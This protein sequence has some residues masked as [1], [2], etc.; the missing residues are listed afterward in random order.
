MSQY[1]KKLSGGGTADSN[2]K[3][4]QSIKVFKTASGNYDANKLAANFERN[5]DEYVNYLGFKKTSKD[6]KNFITE[7]ARIQKGIKDGEFER[8]EGKIYSGSII[9]DENKYQS[10]ALGLLDKIIDASPEYNPETKVADT[11]IKP[12]DKNG[13]KNFFFDVQFGGQQNPELKSW[14][15]LDALPEDG[16]RPTTNRANTFANVLDKYS[17]YLNT[18]NNIDWANSTYKTKEEYQTRLKN[19]AQELRQSGLSSNAKLLLNSIGISDQRQ[20]ELF[21]QHKPETKKEEK[22]ADSSNDYATQKEVLKKNVEADVANGLLTQEEAEEIVDNFNISYK[23]KKYNIGQDSSNDSDVDAYQDYANRHWAGN[24]E[25]SSVQLY[26]MGFDMK[27]DKGGSQA[28]AYIAHIGDN[29]IYNWYKKIIT[30]IATGKYNV[31]NNNKQLTQNGPTYKQLLYA[32]LEYLLSKSSS[33]LRPADDHKNSFYIKPSLN[34]REGSILKWERGTGK[35]FKV[36]IQPNSDSYITKL[37]HDRFYTVFP[38]SRKS[39]NV[40]WNKQGAKLEK[41]K[42]LRT[43]KKGGASGDDDDEEDTIN[44]GLALDFDNENPFEGLAEEQ[45]AVLDAARIDSTKK[46]ASDKQVPIQMVEANQKK[47]SEMKDDTSYKIANLLRSASTVA[48]VAGTTMF[49]LPIPGGAQAVAGVLMA[50]GA[51]AEIGADIIDWADGRIPLSEAAGNAI[52]AAATATMFGKLGKMAKTGVTAAS[53]ALKYGTT[54]MTAFGAGMTAINHDQNKGFWNTLTHDGD[55]TVEELRNSQRWWN[56]FLGTMAGVNNTAKMFIDPTHGG[57]IRNTALELISDPVGTTLGWKYRP[58]ATPEWKSIKNVKVGSN[59]EEM[60]TIRNADNTEVQIKNKDIQ[61]LKDA[62][63]EVVKL[64]KG[65]ETVSELNEAV[66]KRWAELTRQQYSVGD[67]L[68]SANYSKDQITAIANGT[69]NG[70]V[71]LT[72]NIGGKDVEVTI[73]KSQVEGIRETVNNATS[74]QKL[75]DLLK[76]KANPN[77]D[78]KALSDLSTDELASLKQ[79]ATQKAIDDAIQKYKYNYTQDGYVNP[80]APAPFKATIGKKYLPDFVT[81]VQKRVNQV[82]D[83]ALV[84]RGETPET[85][86][87]FNLKTAQGRQ[88]AKAA[89]EIIGGQQGQDPL[90]EY[91]SKIFLQRMLGTNIKTEDY[92]N[93]AY[94]A[95]NEQIRNAMSVNDPSGAMKARW[96]LSNLRRNGIVDENGLLT[97]Y[98]L[99]ELF[100]RMGFEDMTSSQMQELYSGYKRLH[101]ELEQQKVDPL[102]ILSKLHK[103]YVNDDGITD[104][105]NTLTRLN[106]DLKAKVINSDAWGE[107]KRGLVLKDDNGNPLSS[108]DLKLLG[109]DDVANEFVKKYHAGNPENALDLKQVNPDLVKTDFE[110]YNQGLLGELSI[111]KG[112]KAFHDRNPDF[113][114]IA[115]FDNTFKDKVESADIIYRRFE[116]KYPDNPDQLKT[117]RSELDKMVADADAHPWSNDGNDS[118]N[119]AYDRAELS[120][121]QARRQDK[122]AAIEQSLTAEQKDALSRQIAKNRILEGTGKTQEELANLDTR[123]KND[124]YDEVDAQRKR[125]ALE[126]QQKTQIEEQEKAVREAEAARAAAQEAAQRLEAA[127]KTIR[128][129]VNDI[130][131]KYGDFYDSDTPKEESINAAKEA[132]NDCTDII[133]DHFKTNDSNTDDVL[134]QN[135]RKYVANQFTDPKKAKTLVEDIQST[136]TDDS[137][138]Q[139]WVNLFLG[140]P[141]DTPTWNLTKIPEYKKLGG[142]LNKIKL[143]RGGIV[144]ASDGAKTE[145]PDWYLS[146]FAQREMLGTENSKRNQFAGESLTSNNHNEAF[147]LSLASKKNLAYINTPSAVAA[148]IQNFYNNH[149]QSM[150]LEDFVNYYNSQ[151]QKLRDVWGVGQ[152]GTLTMTSWRLN[153]RHGA[154]DGSR[155]FKELYASRSTNEAGPEYNIGYQLKGPGGQDVEDMVGSSFWMRRPDFYQ[156]E[157]AS[158]TDENKKSRTHTITLSNGEKGIVYKKANGDIAIMPANEPSNKP[159]DIQ[160]E[161][162]KKRDVNGDVVGS[163]IG[164][165]QI[166]TKDKL[167]GFAKSIGKFV[168]DHKPDFIAFGRYLSNLRNNRRVLNKILE[169]RPALRSPI[170]EHMYVKDGFSQRQAGYNNAAQQ[171][172]SPALGHSSDQNK[173]LLAY[174]DTARIS[175]EQR[176]KY[177]LLSNEEK[178]KTASQQQNLLLRNYEKNKAVQDFNSASLTESANTKK[179]YIAQTWTANQTNRNTLLMEYEKRLRDLEDELK[180]KKE[181]SEEKYKEYQRL[182]ALQKDPVY[183]KLHAALQKANPNS[184]EW[185][186]IYNTLSNYKLQFK[187]DYTE[188]ELAEEAK[189]Y[190]ADVKKSKPSL[191][192]S[193]SKQGGTID[194]TRIKKRQKDNELI[195]KQILAAINGNEKALDRLSKAQLLSIR[196]ILS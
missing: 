24:I 11:T 57:T 193:I 192:I 50:G 110:N 7:A 196:K 147:D 155:I 41:I 109:I 37:F 19:T 129:K 195:V 127:K 182:V 38:Q 15:D 35:I 70:D 148:D 117:F 81:S 181:T 131:S 4:V 159:E 114:E 86:E 36:Y 163:N 75:Q 31:A 93:L 12:F 100:Q 98:G 40:K 116:K 160:T 74:D 72:M 66:G 125:Q 92:R 154:R 34:L 171:Q 153:D 151:M 177:D 55:M 28:N 132:I 58:G 78:V 152:D 115:D 183:Q 64:R 77:G 189:K 139:D 97:K 156:V 137:F 1:V 180:Y 173:N 69:E 174:L 170:D 48:N 145:N 20:E 141:D 187:L 166:D 175:D 39:G 33:D 80:E 102:E 32:N 76:A 10:L 144:K 45:Q 123:T 138:K 5:I 168:N 157:F 14:T 104:Y 108:E 140:T 82:F 146:R 128:V 67:E 3:D 178:D 119:Q 122:R 17:D 105:D 23:K 89:N 134:K 158:D 112:V 49:F 42:Q 21:G 164:S 46:I 167:K 113:I 165:D 65:K 63:A 16:N 18:Q 101:P 162:V 60:R 90:R 103:D 106:D 29:A 53:K 186:T 30:E 118:W 22:P 172:N 54:G 126:A 136:L 185:S 188:R 47:V 194:D 96:T 59:P 95:D 85:F 133:F 169:K 61:A 26:N 161:N 84:A 62:A 121:E 79:E 120:I 91:L 150:N 149:G 2:N 142:V 27:E 179:D 83:D 51:A 94:L 43:Y 25:K 68:K 88:N 52:I 143:L 176:M 135:I 87:P 9:S 44:D 111:L 56:M 71:K 191:N 13:L 184:T 8:N 73:P 6:Y 190:D 130:K 124:F 99:D 107:F